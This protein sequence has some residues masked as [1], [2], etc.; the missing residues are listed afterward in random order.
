MD[1]HLSVVD[2][3]YS[4]CLGCDISKIAE[5]ETV[6][7]A[8]ERRL[9]RERSFANVFVVW[10]VLTK[11]RCCASV[12][13]RLLGPVARLLGKDGPFD[14]YH[15]E[16][17]QREFAEVTAEALGLTELPYI[18]K[19]PISYCTPQ[20]LTVHRLHPCRRVVS[21]DLPGFVEMGLC[22][23]YH[24]LDESVAD[25]TCFAAYDGDRPV[26]LAGTHEIGIM[27]DRITDA[28]V[29]GVLEECRGRG[30][31]KTVVSHSAEAALAIGKTPV[32]HT[33]DTNIA[34]QRTARVSGYLDYGWQ[35]RLQ[36]DAQEDDG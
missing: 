22:Y 14:S 24:G 30:Y 20:T 31:G 15:G 16:A 29:P 32:Y 2:A 3:F 7:A 18:S 21:E 34:S 5:G 4:Q 6:I 26:A 1:R 28:N 25:G 27:A 8:S 33:S 12:Q 17:F 36:M 11:G 13:E 10:V 23:Q 9:R 35:F 19:G